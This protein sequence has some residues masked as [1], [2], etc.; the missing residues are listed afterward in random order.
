MNR[1]GPGTKVALLMHGFLG[2][3]Q[4]KHGIGMLRYSESRIVAVIDRDADSQTVREKTGIE[5]DARVVA[6]V[7]AAKELGA[8]VLVVAIAPPGGL[9]PEG[10]RE[11]LLIALDYG[12]S[13][14]NPLHT[15]WS[16]DP[17]F[18]S[19]LKPGCWIWDVRQEPPGL[20]PATGAARLLPNR[21]ILTVGTDM[22]VGKM[23]ASLELVRSLK[24]LG[25]SAGMLATGQ[26][27]ITITGNGVPVDAIRLDY[28][29]GAIERETLR[30]ASET[31][32]IVIEGQGALCHPAASAN[33][34][35]IRG[36][37]PTHLL[38]VHRAG[39]TCERQYEWARIPELMDF[40]RLHED[41]A[42]ACGT[43]DRPKTIGIALNTS[44]LPEPEARQ[45][46]ETLKSETGLPV[47]DPIRDSADIF[48]K[49]LIRST[50]RLAR[51]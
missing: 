7:L 1:L 48:A 39:Q 14:V 29:P 15:P 34:A 17:E 10:W 44:H 28:A 9:L 6:D 37:M 24:R 18:C 27:G 20:Q 30:L 33:L 36:S 16:N 13:L 47:V 5:T 23:T 2:H 46:I 19:K 43:F 11:E 38:M 49:T 21:R 40:I 35:L 41:L 3:S 8:E 32:F 51:R 50:E 25:E 12:M 31:D 42:E 4:G 26:V 22:A 45:A